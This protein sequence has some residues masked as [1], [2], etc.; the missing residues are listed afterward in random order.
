[1]THLSAPENAGPWRKPTEAERVVLAHLLGADFV[2]AAGLR[3]QLPALTCRTIDSDGSLELLVSGGETTRVLYR[4]PVEAEYA[5]EDGVTVHVLVHV[6]EEG[7]LVELEV[8]RDDSGAI[9]RR[10]SNTPM[11]A[12]ALLWPGP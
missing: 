3:T 4:V 1:M 7:L 5:D 10:L 6:A 12:L 8:Y 9:L 2:G 11:S